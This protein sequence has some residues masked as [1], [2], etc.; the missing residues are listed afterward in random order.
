MKITNEDVREAIK[1]SGVLYWQV[2]DKYGIDPA[3]FSKMLRHELSLDK[4]DRIFKIIEGLKA[5]ED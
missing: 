5:E 2:A 1:K 4:K 3:T